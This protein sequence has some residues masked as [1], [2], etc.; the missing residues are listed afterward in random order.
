MARVDRRKRPANILTTIAIPNSEI[1]S[2]SMLPPPPPEAADCALAVGVVGVVVV[3][4]GVVG[5][6]FEVAA[7][8]TATDAEAIEVPPLPVQFRT[9]VE[10]ELSVVDACEPV[11]A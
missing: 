1:S 9:N 6:G 3:G 10:A 8:V 7:A 5:A 11:V 2:R 4:G